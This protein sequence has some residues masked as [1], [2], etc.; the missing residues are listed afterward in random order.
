MCGSERRPR[1]LR[2]VIPELASLQGVPIEV[3][4][5]TAAKKLRAVGGIGAWLRT[6][7]ALT[8]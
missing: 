2:T 7:R 4:S 8:A 3:V 1:S 5:G 6:N